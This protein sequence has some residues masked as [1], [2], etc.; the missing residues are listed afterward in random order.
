MLLSFYQY[1]HSFTRLM[2]YCWYW[3][4]RILTRRIE[5]HK[6]ALSF[7]SYRQSHRQ[8]LLWT[9][10]VTDFY[11]PIETH[12]KHNDISENFESYWLFRCRWKLLLLTAAGALVVSTAVHPTPVID[13]LM[14]VGARVGSLASWAAWFLPRLRQLPLLWWATCIR[15]QTG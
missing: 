10:L 14:T 1:L 15:I 12:K 4:V 3:N 7:N 8:Q 5:S 13:A 9:S 2:W 6:L 11:S